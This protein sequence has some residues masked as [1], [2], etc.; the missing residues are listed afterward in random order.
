MIASVL[1]RVLLK[2]QVMTTVKGTIPSINVQ[3]QTVQA[4]SS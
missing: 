3:N 2:I 4:P 1:R